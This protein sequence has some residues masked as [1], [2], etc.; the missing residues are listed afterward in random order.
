MI[1]QTIRQVTIQQILDSVPA[2][3]PQNM[4]KPYQSLSFLRFTR[5]V[6]R[7]RAP[8]IPNGHP[9]H[10]TGNELWQVTPLF[11]KV[12]SH[13]ATP[14]LHFQPKLI[15]RRSPDQL[16]QNV[17][18][19]RPGYIARRVV[20]FSVTVECYLFEFRGWDG[21]DGFQSPVVP[22]IQPGIELE[23]SELKTWRE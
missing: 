6:N 16:D 17:V 3:V 5:P 12:L 9:A 19:M 13:R 23:L 1:L 20:Q 18:Q 7:V 15:T 11:V 21:Q 4:G 22:R 8:I 14:K 10:L 2:H